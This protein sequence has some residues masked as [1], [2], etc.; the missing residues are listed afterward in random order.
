M[1]VN[2]NHEL[3]S[4][5]SVIICDYCVEIVDSRNT[6]ALTSYIHQIMF[7]KYRK[8]NI[9]NMLGLTCIA[10]NKPLTVS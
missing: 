1:S 6:F 8:H 7:R 4:C 2:I 5:F 3:M 10:Q 9:N